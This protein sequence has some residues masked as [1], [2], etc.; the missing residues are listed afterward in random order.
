MTAQDPRIE[1]LNYFAAAL[2]TVAG[3]HVLF[4]LLSLPGALATGEGAAHAGVGRLLRILFLSLGAAGGAVV[5]YFAS[6]IINGR[7]FRKARLAAMGA[8]ALPL[9]GPVGAITIFALLPLGIV[10][11][12]VL[13][14]AEWKGAFAD[15]EADQAPESAASPAFEPGTEPEFS[16]GDPAQ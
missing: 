16:A 8:M 14:K 5:A 12:L 11:L 7:S 9:L 3:I 2:L 6:F 15:G 10:A 4:S 13:G 1:K